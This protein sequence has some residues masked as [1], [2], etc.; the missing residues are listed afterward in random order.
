VR[1]AW[2]RGDVPGG[3]LLVEAA[4]AAAAERAIASLP[5]VERDMTEREIIGLLPY[6][7]FVP[8]T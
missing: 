7:G 3:V 8:K 2:S 1:S 4:D 6:R 5:L